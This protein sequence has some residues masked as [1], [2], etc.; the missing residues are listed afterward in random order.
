MRAGFLQLKKIKNKN[1][2]NAQSLPHL[3]FISIHELDLRQ[4]IL[5]SNKWDNIKN[6]ILSAPFILSNST[7]TRLIV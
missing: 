6:I 5:L 4:H 2:R 3:I 7:K 1:L